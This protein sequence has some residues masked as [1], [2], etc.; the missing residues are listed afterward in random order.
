MGSMGSGSRE[1]WPQ[2]RAAKSGVVR[3]IR[4]T[5]PSGMRLYALRSGF[6]ETERAEEIP[7]DGSY[8][9]R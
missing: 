1:A 2:G 6:V 4:A 5:S 9:A 3:M 8:T 7:I